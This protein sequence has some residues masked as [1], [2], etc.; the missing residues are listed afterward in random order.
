MRAIVVSEHVFEQTPDG[1]VWTKVQCSYS[2]WSQY[3]EVFDSV[4]ILARV[5]PIAQIEPDELLQASGEA[6]DFAALPPYHGPFQYAAA[7]PRMAALIRAAISRTDAVLLRAPSAIAA[8]VCPVLWKRGQAY[9]VHVL[10]DP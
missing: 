6:V 5:R 8:L 10:G 7:G 2:F 4:R 9:A 1:Q 3:L